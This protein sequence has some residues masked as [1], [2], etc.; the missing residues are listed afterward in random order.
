M[1]DHNTPLVAVSACLKE[2][3]TFKMHTASHRHI[4]SLAEVSGVLPIILPAVGRKAD[5]KPLLD[6]ISGLLL[7]GSPSNVHPDFYGEKIASSE[8]L[9]D[10]DR[11]NTTLPMIRGAIERGIPVFA[12]CRGIQ[13]L[14]VAMGGTLHQYVHLL[15]GKRDHR[16]NKALPPGQRAG[17]AHSVKLTAG[18][19]LQKIFG[20]EEVLVN[21]L[22]AQAVN[23][24]APG[25]IV[26]A[27]SEDGV[28]EGI[29]MPSAPGWVLGV[30]WHPEAT[31]RE[32]LPSRKLFEAFGV[33]VQAYASGKALVAAE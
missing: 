17:L 31:F 23:Q 18:G 9:I 32:D 33:A 15:P 30:Q 12:I 22:H 7:T 16:S 25:M 29:S 6:H 1:V 13:E 28:V 8:T 3:N 5:P 11:D 10:L 2:V 19:M 26:E 27:L 24:P 20:N 21:S 14:N 4:E